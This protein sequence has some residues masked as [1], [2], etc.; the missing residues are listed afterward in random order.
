MEGLGSEWI[1]SGEIGEKADREWRETGD[2]VNREWG[3]T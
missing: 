1:E 3:E 2:R